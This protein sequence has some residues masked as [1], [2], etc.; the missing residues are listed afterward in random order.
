MSIIIKKEEYMWI[1]EETKRREQ[2]FNSGWESLGAQPRKGSW[3][4][5]HGLLRIFEI[6]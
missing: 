4:S 3:T 5:A 6:C 1:F 2:E